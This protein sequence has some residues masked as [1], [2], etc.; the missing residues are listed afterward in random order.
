MK[1]ITF[2][3]FFILISILNGNAQQTTFLKTYSSSKQRVFNFQETNTQLYANNFSVSRY[4][5]TDDEET[6]ADEDKKMNKAKRQ[7]N[8]GIS[9]ICIGGVFA[10]GAIA[11]G[12][13]STKEVNSDFNTK[14]LILRGA[15]LGSGALSGV[16][17]GI[18]LPLTIAGAHKVRK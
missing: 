6:N 5:S 9:L 15:A 8:A 1:T 16:F 11:T 7:K 14:N 18:G 13:I 17:L 2:S 4:A 3:C 10:A 12:I